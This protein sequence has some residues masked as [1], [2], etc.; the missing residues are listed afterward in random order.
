M[1]ETED[2]RSQKS[3]VN[4]VV[5][6]MSRSGSKMGSVKSIEKMSNNMFDSEI[7]DDK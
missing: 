5:A 1:V 6:H 7:A 4:D 2:A 3:I